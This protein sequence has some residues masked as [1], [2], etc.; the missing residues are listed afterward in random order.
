MTTQTMTLNRG[1]VS[2]ARKRRL[3]RRRLEL[4]AALFE[5]LVTIGIGACFLICA[6]LV[7]CVI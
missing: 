1:P 3:Y 2:A 7:L 4:L 6:I 5:V